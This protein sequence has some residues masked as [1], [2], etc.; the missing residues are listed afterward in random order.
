MV[1]ME[2]VTG[3]LMSFDPRRMHS[4]AYIQIGD[5]SH[6]APASQRGV[7]E[8]NGAI[9]QCINGE[10][11]EKVFPGMPVTVDLVFDSEG[12]NPRPG[13]WA[14]KPGKRKWP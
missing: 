10:R 14:P 12:K 9:Q 3:T 6:F 11:Y 13:M 4:H 8:D 5:T 1:K 7:L 2:R